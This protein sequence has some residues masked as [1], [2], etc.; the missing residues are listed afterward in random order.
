M[1]AESNLEIVE[2]YMEMGESY[3][4]VGR[5][6]PKMSWPA[7]IMLAHFVSKGNFKK[8]K[9]LSDGSSETKIVKIK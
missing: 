2:E 3:Y 9:I 6:N 7:N 4:V 1:N 8:F 5:K